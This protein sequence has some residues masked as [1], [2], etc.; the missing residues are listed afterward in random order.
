M[1]A[2]LD[3]INRKILGILQVDATRPIAEIADAVGLSAAP[4]WR[5]IRKL[6]EDGFIAR[7]VA[8]LDRR[9]L[10]VPMTIFVS[11]RTARHSAEW[12][13]S[14]RQAI[15]DMPEIQEAWRLSGRDDYLL[16]I[17]A[18]DVEAYDAV[19]KRLI[20]RVEFF[21]ITSSIGMEELKYT[22]SLPLAYL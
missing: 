1:E 6:E 9:K 16:R 12:L 3:A 17:V 18:P 8:L 14:F 10:N 5:R 13:E 4:C 21:D 7:R 19:Y 20:E 22:T 2:K 11:I 15:A